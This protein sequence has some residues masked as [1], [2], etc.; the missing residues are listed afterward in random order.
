MWDAMV[1]QTKPLACQAKM[2]VRQPHGWV[3]K[4]RMNHVYGV[5]VKLAPAWEP[6]Y[7][8]HRILW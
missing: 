5:E 4:L 8:N 2:V 7:A 3:S 6:L 1:S